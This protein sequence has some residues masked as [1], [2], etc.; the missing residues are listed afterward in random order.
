MRLET[1]GLVAGN[2]QQLSLPIEP[3]PPT[4]ADLGIAQAS[5]DPNDAEPVH[6]LAVSL[7]C[8]EKSVDLLQ[9]QIRWRRFF[10]LET[11]DPL[12]G[13]LPG[14]QFKRLDGVTE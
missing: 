2:M 14:E 5:V 10:F 4:V 12:Y 13:V 3:L 6:G 8:F 7:R 11:L 1:E 9:R